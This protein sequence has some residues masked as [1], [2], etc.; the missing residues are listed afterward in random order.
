MEGAFGADFGAVRLHEGAAA[1]DLN[2]RLSARAFTVGRDIFLGSNAPAP[3]TGAGQELL[4]HELTHTLQQGAASPVR[5]ALAERI[6]RDDESDAVALEAS[7]KAVNP[8]YG[9]ALDRHGPGVSD[10]AL[11]KRLREGIAPDNAVVPVAGPDATSGISSRF[12]SHRDYLETRQTASVHSKNRLDLTATT[13]LGL[14]KDTKDAAKALAEETDNTKKG[15]LAKAAAMARKALNDAVTESRKSNPDTTKTGGAE[16]APV[17]TNKDFDKLMKSDDTSQLFQLRPEYEVVIEH[18]RG[19]GYGFKGVQPATKQHNGKDIRV[20][21]DAAPQQLDM[22]KTR[23]TFSV[24]GDKDLLK[25][26]YDPTKWAVIQ[27][28]PADETPG[29]RIK[30][31]S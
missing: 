20:F 27:H 4:A 1:H 18:G 8:H 9:H 3:T 17:D 26:A 16:L 7:D 6:Q 22:T 19:I 10:D 24:Q 14:V 25:R 5:R 2:E 30:G 28:F 31:A 13:L 21:S 12:G 23:T 11:K 29:M 15:G